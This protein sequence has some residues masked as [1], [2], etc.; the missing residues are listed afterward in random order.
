MAHLLQY[1][2][3]STLWKTGFAE[4]HHVTMEGEAV[5]PILTAVALVGYEATIQDSNAGG[6][7]F[8]H[9]YPD[10]P[11][12]VFI[13][14][15]KLTQSKDYITPHPNKSPLVL[16]RVCR[17]WRAV[18]F[19]CQRLWK[20]LTIS[21]PTPRLDR[22]TALKVYILIYLWT[23]AA[24]SP[25]LSVHFEFPGDER[26]GSIMPDAESA[27]ALL[28]IARRFSDR[29]REFSFPAGCYLDFTRVARDLPPALDTLSLYSKADPP[30]PGRPTACS[31][32]DGQDAQQGGPV[33]CSVFD[34]CRSLRKLKLWLEPG[35]FDGPKPF[36]FPW[37][38][39][40]HII[41]T[42]PVTAT[43]WRQIMSRCK[44]AQL[45][46]F[47]IEK[48][49]KPHERERYIAEVESNPPII[50]P[51]L[52]TFAVSLARIAVYPPIDWLPKLELP[53]LA[54][55]TFHQATFR[56]PEVTDLSDE[57]LVS[58]K[59]ILSAKSLRSLSLAYVHMP[60]AHFIEILTRT[61]HLRELNL[62]CN[63]VD[64]DPLCL[65]LTVPPQVS[66]SRVPPALVPELETFM[67]CCSDYTTELPYCNF[68]LTKLIEMTVSRIRNRPLY[69]LHD[70][71]LK[72]EGTCSCWEP[73][74]ADFDSVLELFNDDVRQTI[75][76]T[77]DSLDTFVP[78]V[79][80]Y[81]W[82]W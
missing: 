28:S 10:M 70:V 30:T 76:T 3:P 60:V 29:I 50:L 61:P 47:E 59:R 37:E 69:P 13:P 12:S 62:D 81:Y 27:S 14:I 44:Y 20:H 79:D 42:S 11:M 5:P 21:I 7:L 26:S 45:C 43:V 15:P 65:A 34:S 75:Y 32:A 71:V 41:I 23:I 57:S 52:H 63:L 2:L 16:T 19:G 49:K 9:S 25:S 1:H 80:M 33:D 56:P 73:P 8:Y 36:D 54:K 38:Q 78:R 39:L 46:S 58:L 48:M 74:S 51:N 82:D 64:Y 18:A 72:F 53:A 24:R 66:D 31:K 67:I 35:S 17:Q 77:L 4:V 40:T 6:N 55:F 68:T 22:P